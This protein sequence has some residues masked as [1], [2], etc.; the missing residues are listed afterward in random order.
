M[1]PLGWIYPGVLPVRS[2]DMPCAWRAWRPA[3]K[4]ALPRISPLD[5]HAWSGDSIGQAGRFALSLM[6]RSLDCAAT[7][8]HP[9]FGSSPGGAPKEAKKSPSTISW[10]AGFG[11]RQITGLEVIAVYLWDGDR[12]ITGCSPHGYWVSTNRFAK[13][14]TEVPAFLIVSLLWRQSD[15]PG[16]VSP[17]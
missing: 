4:S 3:S 5:I 6:A 17:A 10:W 16:T 12:G 8:L 15:R 14:P 7:L 1:G 11:G 9:A 13:V 2:V